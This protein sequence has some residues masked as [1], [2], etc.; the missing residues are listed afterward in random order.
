MLRARSLRFV[1]HGSVSGG[2]AAPLALAVFLLGF[3]AVGASAA[4]DYLDLRERLETSRENLR[5]ALAKY[6]RPA[7]RLAF[8]ADK[9]KAFRVYLDAALA[10][11]NAKQEFPEVHAALSKWNGRLESAN[12]TQRRALGLFL[13]DYMSV[14]YGDDLVRELKELV[15]FRTFHN[16]VSENPDNPEFQSALAY[17]ADLAQG[18]DLSVVKHGTET[19]EI[20]LEPAKG[21]GGGPPVVMFTHVEVMRPVEYKWDQDTPPFSMQLKDGRWVGCGV[22]GDKGPVVVNLFALKVLRDAGLV[23][24]RPLVLLVGTQMSTPTSGI[25]SSLAMLKTPPALVLAADGTF[26]YSEG[27]MGDLVARV[28]STRGMKSTAGLKPGE[29]YIY[30]MSSYYSMNTVPAETRV[31]VLYKDPVNSTNP[32]LDMVTKWRGI[33]EPHQTTIPVSR[34]G[35][36]VQDDTLHFFSYTLPSHVESETGRNAIMDMASAL[37]KAPMLTNSAWD[38][39]RFLD[40]GLR[41]DPTGKAAGLYYED[42]KMGSTR[43]NPVQFDRIGEEVAVLVDVRFPAGHDR[44]WIKTR[45]AD[46]VT[47]FNRDTKTQLVLSW[48][49]EGREPVQQ[50]PPPT[51]RDWLVDAYEL[52]SGDIGAEAAGI[53]RSAGNLMPPAIPF[54]PERPSVDK[55]G[56][57]QHES[58]SERELSDLSVAYCSALAWFSS[59]TA[60]P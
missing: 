57:T 40:T 19:L 25:A 6:V 52:G 42:P 1:P 16:V 20:R 17:L 46:L 29:F 59:A 5:T 60:V 7:D 34:Y 53:S 18:L 24:A 21:Q 37:A 35:T 3:G 30:K 9:G 55:H 14:R 11:T 43:V 12:D 50:A 56:H 49:G 38:I 45:F 33:M 27:Q 26:P 31:W 47:K 28:A 13:G 48:E 23:L 41:S 54:G 32:S 15:K 39:I 58:I 8:P 36:Y 2:A 10:A 4:T 22:Y 51:V 44:G